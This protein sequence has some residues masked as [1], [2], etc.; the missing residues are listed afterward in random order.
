[1]KYAILAIALLACG[2]QQAPKSAEDVIR[3]VNLTADK[4]DRALDVAQ[5]TSS[6]VIA[7]IDVACAAAPADSDPCKTANQVIQR[8]EL[9]LD[10]AQTAVDQYRAFTGTFADATR[11][12]AQVIQ[13]SIEVTKTAKP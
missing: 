2:P 5:D 1:M 3:E 6:A 9:A 13:L 8:F 10:R 12:L 11:A 7:G 4:L